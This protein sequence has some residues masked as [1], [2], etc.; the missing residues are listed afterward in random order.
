MWSKNREA[1][2]CEATSQTIVRLPFRGGAQAERHGDRGLADAALAG[3]EDE[4][5]VEE[6]GYR[7]I[8]S[9]FCFG[10]EKAGTPNTRAMGFLSRRNKTAKTAPAPEPPVEEHPIVEELRQME[11][12]VPERKPESAGPPA[13]AE[14]ASRRRGVAEAPAPAP[15]QPER[16]DAASR[17][18]WRRRGAEAGGGGA[19]RPPRRRPS[20]P[21]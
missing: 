14:P 16:F 1:F 5:L 11:E 10:K 2:S 7:A 8:P 6:F 18:G 9:N 12:A 15:E 19:A 3:N 17:T 4:P 20:T 21:R 13:P